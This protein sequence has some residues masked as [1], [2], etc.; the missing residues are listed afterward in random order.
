VVTWIKARVRFA[1]ATSL[2]VPGLA[3]LA[4]GAGQG[5]CRCSVGTCLEDD[6]M[7]VLSLLACVALVTATGQVSAGDAAAGETRFKQLC[8]TCHGPTGKGDGPA[9]P[10][11]NPKPRD[12][13][14]AAW[15]SSVDDEYLTNIIQKGGAAI[16]KSPM[17]TPFGHALN[18][19][20]MKD[21]IAYIRKLDD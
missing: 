19:Q 12:M 5:A 2:R 7:R 9:A 21:V 1:L 14:D 15:Q 8:G 3:G 6:S 18:A 17:M 4:G 11:L 20:Q 10:G 13:S 16:G